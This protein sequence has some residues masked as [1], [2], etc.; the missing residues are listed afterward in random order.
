MGTDLSWLLDPNR[1]LVVY[2]QPGVSIAANF[3]GTTFGSQQGSAHPML[4]YHSVLNFWGWQV[5]YAVVAWPGGSNVGGSYDDYTG[6]LSH[7]IAET[8][9]DPLGNGWYA[10][11]GNL[12]SEIG[13]SLEGVLARMADG[14]AVQEVLDPHG[15]PIAP[16][17]SRPL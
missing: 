4:G 16:P 8:A 12:V 5:P 10:Q 11:V 14:T 7:E 2:V 6:T 9:T 13:D 1:M 15:H 17:G 3:G